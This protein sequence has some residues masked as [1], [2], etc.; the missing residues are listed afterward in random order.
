MIKAPKNGTVRKLLFNIIAL[1]TNLF[2]VY[3]LSKHHPFRYS[4]N[5]PKLFVLRA[6][7]YLVQN[8]SRI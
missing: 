2:L 7:I 1:K 4:K 5:R 6:E 8:I 3:I